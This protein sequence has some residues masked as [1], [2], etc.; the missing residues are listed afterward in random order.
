M[1]KQQIIEEL[2]R[3]VAT[4]PIDNRGRRS[5]EDCPNTIAAMMAPILKYGPGL[6]LTLDGV[7]K[8]IGT[9]RKTLSFFVRG[10]AS[11]GEKWRALAGAMRKA[12]VE[13]V[14]NRYNSPQPTSALSSTPAPVPV[15][16]VP[17][18]IPGARFAPAW[19][20]DFDVRHDTAEKAAEASKI[21]RAHK[22]AMV[23]VKRLWTS[24]SEAD[25]RDVATDIV[26]LHAE[27]VKDLAK[28]LA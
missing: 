15:A 27:A 12:G 5:W 28:A 7:A 4:V 13:P 24:W 18:S 2:T 3:L 1:D 11:N 20:D 9:S 19:L 21:G 8:A 26:V 6:G 22:A 23:L 17:A 25:Q 10:R 16:K 14:V